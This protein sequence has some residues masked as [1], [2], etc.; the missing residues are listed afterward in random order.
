MSLIKQMNKKGDR[1]SPC[2]TPMKLSKYA[3]L[4]LFEVFLH[5]I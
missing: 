3:E 1:G 2:F 5:M 4:T